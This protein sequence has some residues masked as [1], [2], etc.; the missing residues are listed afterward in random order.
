M[1]PEVPNEDQAD[2][3]HVARVLSLADERGDFVRG[4]DGYTYYWPTNEASRG[5][6]PSWALRALADEMDKRD[7]T[8]HAIIAGDHRIG[9]PCVQVWKWDQAPEEWKKLSTHGGDEDWLALVPTV[10]LA[11]D[12]KESELWWMRWY[13]EVNEGGR[14]SRRKDTEGAPEGFEIWIGAHA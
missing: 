5:C 12:Q 13:P 7:T 3:D 2:M 4:D 1:K 10:M 9:P 8:W 14:V 6:L 11:E